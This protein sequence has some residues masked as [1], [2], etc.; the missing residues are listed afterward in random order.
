MQLTNDGMYKCVACGVKH[1][2]PLMAAACEKTHH[3]LY[4]PVYKEDLIKFIQFLFTGDSKLLP[5]R[6]MET[7]MRYSR[8]KD[9]NDTE[10]V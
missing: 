6:L 3:I 5:E 2:N 9:S 4:M 1:T 8:M 10:E 7:V